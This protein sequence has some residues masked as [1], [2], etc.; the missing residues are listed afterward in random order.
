MA[1][2]IKSHGP[3]DKCGSSDAR[4]EYADGGWHCFS[5]GDHG[6]AGV[7]RNSTDANPNLIQGRFAD[8]PARDILRDTCCRY[9]YR[10]GIHN[11]EQVHIAEYRRKGKVVAQKLRDVNKN[12]SILGDGR[13]LDLFGMHLFRQ[14]GK[15]IVITEGEIDCLSVAQAFNCNW[16]VVSLPNGA[17]G[18]YATLQRH[19]EYL[20]SYDEIVLAF[21][22]DDPGRQAVEKCAGLFTPG[23]LK[24]ACWAP[25]KDANETLQKEG[26]TRVSQAIFEAKQYRPG[27][28]LD[29]AELRRK[30]SETKDY[31]SYDIPFPE[32]NAAMHGLRKG[33]LTL[34]VAGTGIGKSTVIKEIGHYIM[35]KHV[36][37]LGLI[38]L[39]ENPQKTALSMMAI[40]LNKPLGQLLL[41]RDC[42]PKADY[43]AALAATVDNGRLF[44][45]DHFGSLDSSNLVSKMRY[46][47]LGCG[48][49][50]IILDHVS[51]VVS[52]M[53]E[54]GSTERKMIDM[55][56][57]QCRM[58]VENTGVGMLAISHLRKGENTQRA[59]EEGGRVK[60]QHIRGS[61]AFGQI[62]DN[63]IAL[64]RD[65]QSDNES[66]V[67]RV[68]LLKC[69]LFGEN[70][71]LK[72]TLEY[73]GDTGRLYSIGFIPETGT[74]IF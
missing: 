7:H 74:E 65:T 10:I 50:F 48:V 40:Q 42:V 39:E 68:R 35:M 61:G 12:F 55:L 63:V 19:L 37:K 38:M 45:Y 5:C 51:I 9:G 13:N 8:L 52:G 73:N 24:I 44:M 62:S 21:D 70:T 30:L 15:R 4:T 47:V 6:S 54:K 33:E 1:R 3:C 29:G 22:D 17:Q 43:D 23:K 34:L 59:H 58:L 64:E 46:M 66:D 72:D 69:R 20:D 25:Y 18:A 26:R 32:L 2:Q 27:G 60:L 14:G 16:P 53:E 71:G 11:G 36:L 41:D 49:D 31:P 56:A 28:I 67:L 57:T